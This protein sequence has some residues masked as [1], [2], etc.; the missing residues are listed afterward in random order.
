MANQ[1]VGTRN[2][3]IDKIILNRDSITSTFQFKFRLD[4]INQL[5]NRKQHAGLI[6]TTRKIHRWMGATL[7]L[8]FLLISISGLLLIWKK[9]SGGVI[10]PG[11]A[12]GISQNVTNWLPLD[13]L[14]LISDSVIEAQTGKPAQIDR[15]DIRPEKGVIK[16]IYKDH[17]WSTQL[18]GLS[19]EVLRVERRNH[20]LI[21]DIHDGVILDKQMGTSGELLKLI[22]GTITGLALFLFTVTGFWLWFGPKMMRRKPH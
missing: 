2:I 4:F 7:F 18:D 21:E 13:R 22:Y 17:Y 8:L 10:Y 19:G 6:R 20:D 16:F 3:S 12:K 15:L 5:M 14:L 9:N 1:Y 11:T